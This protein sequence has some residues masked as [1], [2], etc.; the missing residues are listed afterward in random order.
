MQALDI[1]NETGFAVM[2]LGLMDEE[3]RP[4]L[5]LLAKATFDILPSEGSVERA[6][7]QAPIQ[8]QGESQG[9]PLRS[10]YRAEPETAFIKPMVDVVL[11]GHAWAGR[12]GATSVDVSL[13]VGTLRKVVRVFGDRWWVRGISGMAISAPRPFEKVPLTWEL[14]FG[15]HAPTTGPTPDAFEARNP[16]GLGFRSGLSTNGPLATRQLPNLEDPQHLIRAP[17]DEPRPT[18]F[19]FVSPHWQPRAALAGT[20][21]AGWEEERAPLLP[22]DF[23]RRHFNAAPEDQQVR[24]LQGDEQVELLNASAMGSLRFRLPGLSPPVA[25]VRRRSDDDVRLETTL[26]TVIIDTDELR[27]SLLFRAHLVLKRDLTEVD[28]VR[29]QFPETG[30]MR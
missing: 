23:D 24:V 5:A 17:R 9:D 7:K 28:A 26:D 6:E 22:S 27:L 3:G 14:A 30:S 29:I 21:D 4:L 2:P 11:R 13:R 8:P 12:P 20:Y 10:S 15:G 18:G 1:E 19:G 16:V 25:L